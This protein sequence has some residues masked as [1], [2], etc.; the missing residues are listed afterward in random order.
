MK[1]VEKIF[2]GFFIFVCL[3]C[4]FCCFTVVAFPLKYKNTILKECEINNVDS[5]LV[6]SIIYAESRFKKD[7]VSSKG[8]IGLMQIMPKTGESFYDGDN[9]FDCLLLYDPKIN[10]QIGVEFLQYLFK[11]YND[12]VTV[13]ACYNAGEGVVNKWKGN[14]DFLQK[15]QIPYKETLNY[16]KKVQKVKKIY[17][18]RIK[19]I[20]F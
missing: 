14:N 4:C 6:A 5:V 16:V 13:L 7:I 9:E 11:K 18:F 15:T 8:A 19:N 17:K 2:I 1:K 3:I 10:I 20:L 12:E